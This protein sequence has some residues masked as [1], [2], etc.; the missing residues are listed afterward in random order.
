MNLDNRGI[1][2]VPALSTGD[3]R[4]MLVHLRRA[5][6]LLVI[7]CAI[8]G[9]CVFARDM[10]NVHLGMP[11]IGVVSEGNDCKDCADLLKATFLEDEVKAPERIPYCV[12]DIDALVRGQRRDTWQS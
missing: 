1:E 5:P 4:S 12:D 11:I 10:A 6:D 3:A 7:N 9:A 2:S 8:L